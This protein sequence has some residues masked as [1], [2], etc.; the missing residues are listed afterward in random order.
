MNKVASALILPAKKTFPFKGHIS[1]PSSHL[2]PLLNGKIPRL[3]SAFRRRHLKMGAEDKVSH[4]RRFKAISG[5]VIVDK[6]APG[7]PQPRGQVPSSALCFFRRLP[8]VT[9]PKGLFTPN[10]GQALYKTFYCPAEALSLPGSSVT[11]VLYEINFVWGLVYNGVC[12][13]CAGPF[14]RSGL[15][16]LLLFGLSGMI[17]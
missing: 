2:S 11:C 13:C 7:A 8:T 15:I 12:L 5:D 1:H 9:P 14:L 3:Q 16:K 6:R 4:N 10:Y 17:L